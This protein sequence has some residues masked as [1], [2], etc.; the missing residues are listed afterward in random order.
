VTSSSWTPPLVEEKAPFKN[1]QNFG[2]NN[3]MVTGPETKSYCAGK[4]QQQLN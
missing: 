3:N 4:G 1:P 2:K